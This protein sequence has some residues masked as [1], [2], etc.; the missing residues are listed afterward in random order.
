MS[1]GQKSELRT[2]AHDMVHKHTYFLLTAVG[3]SVGFAVTQTS[4][5]SLSLWFIP[6]GVA[7]FAWALSFI[8]GCLSLRQRMVMTNINLDIVMARSG[9]HVLSRKHGA[10]SEVLVEIF[11][12]QMMSKSKH[13]SLYFRWQ[14]YLF[15]VGVLFFISWHVLE[16]WRRIPENMCLWV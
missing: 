11:T 7:L 9:S 16:M 15:I 13:T 1:D 14:F 6:L 5:A 8:F 4:K 3:A 10:A 12:E 2:Q